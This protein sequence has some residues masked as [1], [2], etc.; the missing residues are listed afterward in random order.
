MELV[1]QAH[2]LALADLPSNHRVTKEQLMGAGYDKC[3]QVLGEIGRCP[4]MLAEDKESFLEACSG[5]IE[6]AFEA[7]DVSN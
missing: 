4:A 6:G 7:F 1:L 5:D 3:L 2:P